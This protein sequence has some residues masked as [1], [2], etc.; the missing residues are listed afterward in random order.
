MGKPIFGV[1]LKYGIG[2]QQNAEPADLRLS[3]GKSLQSIQD[4]L[5]HWRDEID[6]PAMAW[7]KSDDVGTPAE[8]AI[9]RFRFLVEQIRRAMFFAKELDRDETINECEVALEMVHDELSRMDLTAETL[10]E[11]VGDE[12]QAVK[13]LKEAMERADEMSGIALGR[14]RRCLT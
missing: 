4:L 13:I 9:A 11:T 6:A 1:S 5:K 14:L 10:L 12:Q 2:L 8:I 7:D 3:L